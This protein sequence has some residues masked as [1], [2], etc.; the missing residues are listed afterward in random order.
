MLLE[1]SNNVNKMAINKLIKDSKLNTRRRSSSPKSYSP[2]NNNNNNSNSDEE[3]NGKKNKPYGCYYCGI[4]YAYKYYLVK[5]MESHVRE[6]PYTCSNSKCGKQ[7]D[8]KEFLN[9]HALITNGDNTF[10]CLGCRTPF[11]YGPKGKNNDHDMY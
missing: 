11:T 4:K 3:S 9:A 8:R 6:K 10:G 1:N 7:Y 2:T 5:H